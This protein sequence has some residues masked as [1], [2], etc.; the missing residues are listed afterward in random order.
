MP[1]C[2]CQEQMK[3]K[4]EE[5]TYEALTSSVAQTQCEVSARV[6]LRRESSLMQYSIF[7]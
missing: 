5:I 7:L 1:L 3:Q 6:A 4:A 2:V